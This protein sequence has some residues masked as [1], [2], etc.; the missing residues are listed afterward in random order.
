V[1]SITFSQ[2]Q[3]GNESVIKG[4]KQTIQQLYNHKQG[5]F[6][7]RRNYELLTLNK[8]SYNTAKPTF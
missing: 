5:S 1:Y 2:S 8:V 6:S 7:E 3:Y 4:I